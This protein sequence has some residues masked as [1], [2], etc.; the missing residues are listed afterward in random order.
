MEADGAHFTPLSP[1]VLCQG[2]KNWSYTNFREIETDVETLWIEPW[3]SS[4]EGRALNILGNPAEK[5]Y[6]SFVAPTKTEIPFY[7]TFY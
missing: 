7:T 4:S 1:S 6:S 2:F 3:T 5:V